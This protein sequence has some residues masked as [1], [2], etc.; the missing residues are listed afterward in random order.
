MTYLGNEQTIKQ[1]VFRS[2]VIRT[3]SSQPRDHGLKPRE[4]WRRTVDLLKSMALFTQQL[5]GTG[6]QSVVQ[7]RLLGSKA[8]TTQS[9]NLTFVI[10]PRQGHVG[11]GRACKYKRVR[12]NK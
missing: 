6:W 1:T 7:S 2:V 12:A 3:F 4:E 8:K 5:M 9:E 11:L 10:P